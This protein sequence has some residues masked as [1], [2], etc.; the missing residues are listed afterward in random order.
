MKCSSQNLVIGI[1]R[2]LIGLKGASGMQGESK[3]DSLIKEYR[4]LLKKGTRKYRHFMVLFSTL[5][6]GGNY[7]RIH[8]QKER[9]SSGSRGA[10]YKS[11]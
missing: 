4:E 8:K 11:T 10:G 1:S 7:S 2:D 5:D 3:R 6:R 9:I